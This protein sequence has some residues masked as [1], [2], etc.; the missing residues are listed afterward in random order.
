MS[1]HLNQET[2]LLPTMRVPRET[3]TTMLVETRLEHEDNSFKVFVIF[4]SKS[5]SIALQGAC[6]F[7]IMLERR[8]SENKKRR[9]KKDIDLINDN[10]DAIARMIADMR[11]AARED[12][13]L[14]KARLVFN[15]QI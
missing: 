14:N 3:K 7:D 12:R 15:I 10:D 11:M 1:H 9:R 2:F 4:Y 8:K 13:D 5:F 6:D